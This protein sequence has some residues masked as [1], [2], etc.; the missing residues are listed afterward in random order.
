MI[1]IHEMTVLIVDDMITMCK[2]IQNMMRVIGYGRNFLFAYNGKEALDILQKEPIDVVLLDYNMPMMNGAEALSHIREDRNLRDLPVIMI[3]AEAYQDYVAEAAESVID[4]YILKPLT[5]KLLEEKI[6]HVVEKANNPPPMV[7]HLK[8]AMNFE[9]EGDINGAI[10]EAKLA[11]KTDPHS[12]KPVRDLGY[13]CYKNNDLKEAEK[14]L[15]KA[16]EMNYM[17]VFAFHYLGELYLKLNDIEKSQQYFEKAMR[18]SPRHLTRG[19]HFAKTLVQRKMIIR[20][21]EVFDEVLKLSGSTIELREEIADFCADAG[22]NQY[23][24]KLLESILRER[25]DRTDLLFKLGKTLEN[26]DE[27]KKAV[28]CLVKASVIDKENIEI[29]IHLAKDYLSLGKPIFAEKALKNILKINPNHKEA[30][31]LLRKCV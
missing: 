13:Y 26:L 6:S 12:P 22:A 25:P 19:I 4:A 29:K 10:K 24:A 1:D 9:D 14:W 3:T 21:I 7:Y 20:A 11:M 2:S 23:A 5:I 15:L 16:A 31:E 8:R 17:D 28:T 27:I 18:I 30:K